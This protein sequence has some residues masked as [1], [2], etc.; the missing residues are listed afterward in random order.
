MSRLRAFATLLVASAALFAAGAGAQVV[1]CVDAA[2]KV[3]YTDSG[4]A[5]GDRQS[6]VVLSPEATQPSAGPERDR[7]QEQLDSVA[8]ARQLQRESVETV[9]RQS[10]PTGGS[11]LVVID[12]RGEQ[13][14]QAERDQAERQQREAQLAADEASRQGYAGPGYGGGGYP[15]PAPPPRDMRPRL[16]QCDAS[17]CRDNMGNHYD[18]KGNVDRYVQPDGRTCRPV[19]T[20]VVCQ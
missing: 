18:P 8:R 20:T 4:C 15:R 13:R 1:R 7:R 3:R 5:K 10:A 12:P 14:A 17:G 9:Q 19:N 11:G 2:G 6:E 16:R